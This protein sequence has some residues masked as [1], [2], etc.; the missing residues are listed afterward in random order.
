[1][2]RQF[3]VDGANISIMLDGLIRMYNSYKIR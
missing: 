3:L 2:S 1:M